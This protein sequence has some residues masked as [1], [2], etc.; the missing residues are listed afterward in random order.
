MELTNPTECD[1]TK[2]LPMKNY[3]NILIGIALIVLLFLT[4]ESYLSILV[5]ILLSLI[6]GVIQ[7]FFIGYANSPSKGLFRL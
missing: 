5:I 2:F 7:R 6:L 1:K 4:W 3:F